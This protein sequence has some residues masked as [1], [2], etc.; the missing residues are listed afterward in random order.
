MWRQKVQMFKVKYTVQNAKHCVRM[1]VHNESKLIY[2]I[3]LHYL[4]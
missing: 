1:N 4:L 2:E 3:S